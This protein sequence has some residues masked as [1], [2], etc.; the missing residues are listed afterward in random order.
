MDQQTSAPTA[1]TH[2]NTPEDDRPK[3]M[4][5]PRALIWSGAMFFA[6]FLVLYFLA[7]RIR[8]EVPR[9]S[10]FRF[11]NIFAL[12]MAVP[13]A[14]S[15][16]I[17]YASSKRIAR[18][19]NLDFKKAVTNFVIAFTPPVLAAVTILFHSVSS[20]LRTYAYFPATML[21]CYGLGLCALR[22]TSISL[23]SRMG[24]VFVILGI[25]SIFSIK[26]DANL[27]ETY[28]FIFFG[29]GFGGM[30]ILAGRFIAMNYKPEP[31]NP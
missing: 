29:I 28:S 31:R 6:S 26:G 24:I 23:V 9:D 22:W 10:I 8:A 30:H 4:L 20:G 21:I 7:D 3:T 2:G 11:R 17:V 27:D 13:S 5:G 18:K 1:S 12:A 16:A 25:C 19:W 14:I 15:L